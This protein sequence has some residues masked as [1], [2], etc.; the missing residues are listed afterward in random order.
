MTPPPA[1]THAAQSGSLRLRPVPTKVV[2]SSVGRMLGARSWGRMRFLIDVVVLYLASSAALFADGQIRTVNDN[3]VLAAV[4]PLL[5]IGILYARRS[6]D[7]RMYASLLDTATHVV[8]VVS[9]AAMLTIATGSILGMEHPLGIAVRLWLFSTVYLGAARTVLLSVRRQ[10]VRAEAFATPTLIIGAGMVGE[11]LVRRLVSEPRYGLRPVGFLD[12]NPMPRRNGSDDAFVPVLGGP[13]D[14]ARAVEQTDARQVILAFSSEPDQVLVEAVNECQRLGVEVAL[15]PRLYE[16][17]NE[18][19][20]LDH[21]GGLP[22]VTLRPTDPRGWQ[23][24]VKH[25]IDRSF[26]ALALLALAPLMIGI[27]IAVRLT[28]PGPIMFR[29]RRIGRDGHVFEVLKFR[30]MRE[31]HRS[32]RFRPADG[33][34]PGRR[35][36]H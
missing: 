23:F 29:Q 5:V 8:G 26:A 36:G 32:A 9:L 27:A 25:T 6:P 28:S 4:F 22:L 34:A 12:S 35:R 17:I 7:E 13:Q 2:A 10:A 33:F 31:E 30:T 14:L 15:V 1:A 18:R 11:H 19:S 20:T 24:A 16:S 3:H 21:I